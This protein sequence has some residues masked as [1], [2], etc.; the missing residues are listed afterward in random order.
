MLDEIVGST[1]SPLIS[2]RAVAVGQA[3]VALRMSVGLHRRPLAAAP[4]Q[5]VAVGDVA[6]DLRHSAGHAG[7]ALG[8]EHRLDLRDIAK[9]VRAEELLD[10]APARGLPSPVAIVRNMSCVRADMSTGTR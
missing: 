5:R 6:L 4:A 2:T 10:A 7:E 1:W 8:I 3:Q 9:A